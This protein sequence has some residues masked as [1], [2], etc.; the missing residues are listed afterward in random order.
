MKY[1]ILG[2]MVIIVG[3]SITIAETTN[4]RQQIL[5]IDCIY[6]VVNAGTQQLRYI[7][8]ETCPIDPGP[9]VVTEPP[10]TNMIDGSVSTRPTWSFSSPVRLVRPS[11]ASSQPNEPVPKKEPSVQGTVERVQDIVVNNRDALVLLVFASFGGAIFYIVAVRRYI[12]RV[13]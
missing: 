8:P 11:T 6:E 13:L 5:P 1:L 10:A 3:S 7:T 4:F 12:R 9:P 2:L